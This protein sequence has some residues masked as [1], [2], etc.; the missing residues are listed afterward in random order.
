VLDTLLSEPDILA[1]RP[2]MG[3]SILLPEVEGMAVYTLQG[4]DKWLFA[5]SAQPRTT[6][7]MDFQLEFGAHYFVQIKNGAKE[8][9]YHSTCARMNGLEPSQLFSG[10]AYSSFLLYKSPHSAKQYPLYW[11]FQLPT[12]SLTVKV[13]PTHDEQE[14]P[15]KRSSF[16]MGAIEVTMPTNAHLQDKHLGKGN[17]FIF[18]QP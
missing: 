18:Q 13:H 16:W 2:S 17:M 3:W 11:E 1:L 6:L 10:V 4:G 9:E 15:L 8:G 7:W 14:F 5:P 12:D